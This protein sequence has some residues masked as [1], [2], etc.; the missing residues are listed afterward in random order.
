MPE[1]FQAF[2]VA[3]LAVLPG[4]LYTWSFERVVGRWGSGAADRVLR[5]TGSSA[6]LLALYA[7]PAYLLWTHY[8]HLRTVSQHSVVYRNLIWEGG[9]LPPWLFLLPLAYVTIPIAA[10]TFSGYAVT[11]ARRVDSRTWSASRVSSLAVRLLRGLGTMCS[12]AGH[13]RSCGCT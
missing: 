7:Y 12:S 1:T 2:A 9:A 8:L 11:R 4:A 10:G 5:F 3:A 13:K 6:V